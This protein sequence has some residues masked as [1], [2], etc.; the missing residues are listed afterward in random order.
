MLP[1][2]YRLTTKRLKEVMEMGQRLRGEV[3]QISFLPNS[4]IGVAIVVSKKVHNLSVGRHKIKRKISGIVEKYPLPSCGVVIFAQKKTMFSTN[5]EAEEEYKN[6]LA[7][8]S[9]VC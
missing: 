9:S 6:L 1:K 8:L 2:K 4:P 3:F 7:R 5:L